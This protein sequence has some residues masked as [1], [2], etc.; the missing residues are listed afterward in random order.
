MCEVLG[1]ML[2]TQKLINKRKTMSADTCRIAKENLEQ[3]AKGQI[4]CE[5]SDFRLNM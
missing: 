1:L 2:S 5:I 3:R 4:N